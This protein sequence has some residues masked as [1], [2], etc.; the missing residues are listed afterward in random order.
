MDEWNI[1]T[2]PSSDALP[3]CPPLSLTTDQAWFP[4]PT[5]R[6]SALPV[7]LSSSLP[8]DVESLDCLLSPMIKSD[9]WDPELSLATPLTLGSPMGWR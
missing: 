6:V 8:I 4:L 9:R 5:L 3:R 7:A 1:L 2:E